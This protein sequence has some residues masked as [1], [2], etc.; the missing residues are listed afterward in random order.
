MRFGNLGM[1]AGDPFAD[2]DVVQAEVVEAGELESPRAVRQFRPLE[3][4]STDDFVAVEP[5]E[6]LRRFRD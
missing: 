4:P 5:Q 2:E 1:P 3:E 6:V